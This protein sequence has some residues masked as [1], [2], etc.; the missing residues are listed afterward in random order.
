[1]LWDVEPTIGDSN[2]FT[3]DRFGMYIH[4]GLYSLGARHEWLKGREFMT[5]E[6]YNK[7][8]KRFDPDLY[9]PQLWAQLAKDAGMKYMVVTTKHHEGF[10][11]WDTKHS[12]Y[13]ATNTPAGRDL[14][15]PMLDAFREQDIRT[16]LYYSLLDWYHPHYTVDVKHPLRYNKEFLAQQ[17]ER[18]WQKYLDFMFAQ[19][20]ELL[21]D[22]GKIDVMFYDF[23]IPSLEGFPAKGKEEWQSE[24][25]VKMIRKLQ[26]QLLLNDRLQVPAD[27]TTPEQ[28]QPRE[29]IKVNGKRVVWEACHTFSG[30]WGYYRDEET[31]K[32]VDTL[33]KMLV[34]TVGK[35][36]NLLLNVGPT[37]RGE[38]DERAVDRLKGMGEWMRRHDRSIYGCTAAPDSLPCPE[39]CRFT[40]NPETNR[41]YIH[42]FSWP[43]KNL[44]LT[45]FSGKVE[46]AQ[47]LHDASEI[48]M[49]EGKREM[50]MEAGA[51]NEG[52]PEDMLTLSLPVK[53]PNVTVP[54]IELFLKDGVF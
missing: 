41:L 15:R 6:Q 22:Y 34:D 3:R 30:S 47:L 40:Y 7:Y 45:G 18:D 5:N 10:S 4:W 32:S 35:G 42:I 11:L 36:G 43:F 38:I 54:V 27:I 39:D 46:Y 12:D 23:S 16:G 53:K 49:T 25:L 20:E 28:Y 33:I 50:T 31:W 1:M 29:W 44:H 17:S 26:P 51:F 9:D 21:T 37:G 14:L 24:K 2:W 48:R 19:T 13:K 52:R 8:F